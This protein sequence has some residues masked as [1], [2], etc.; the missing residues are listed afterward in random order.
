MAGAALEAE[1]DDA[2]EGTMAEVEAEAVDSNAL[3]EGRLLLVAAGAARE[4][5][6]A[7]A[8]AV[9][10]SAVSAVRPCD[11]ESALVV[12]S[13]AVA[14]AVAVVV[15]VRPA[16]VLGGVVAPFEEDAAAAPRE[17]GDAEGEGSKSEI[18]ELRERCE[19]SEGQSPEVGVQRSEPWMDASRVPLEEG[20][21]ERSH[22][23]SE[24]RRPPDVLEV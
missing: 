6:T 15:L 9:S 3:A 18:A 17:K 5:S 22:D 4:A 11:T 23:K 16:V 10:D 8:A 24:M 1:D 21:C 13:D 19:P 12:A 20:V 14:V 7:A 2:E